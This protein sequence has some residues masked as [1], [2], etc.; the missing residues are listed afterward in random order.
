VSSNIWNKLYRN[1]EMRALT[2]E[3]T[4]QQNAAIQCYEAYN[5]TNVRVPGYRTENY[6]V[7]CEVRTE[8]I[9]VT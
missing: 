7:S 9:Y 4:V 2:S 6:C 8:F 3:Y 1:G 5:N